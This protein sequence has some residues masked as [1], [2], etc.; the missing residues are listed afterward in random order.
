[1]SEDDRENA[2]AQREYE[3]AIE[4]TKVEQ[5]RYETALEQARS[6][7]KLTSSAQ[8]QSKVRELEEKLARVTQ[9]RERALS[10]A[11]LTRSG[12]VYVISNVGSFGENVFK[13]GMTR[14][15]DPMDR[16]RELGDASVPFAFDVHA[17]I[18]S[19]DAPALERALHLQ[20]DANRVN[21]VNLKKEF[22]VAETEH[23][24]KTLLA[25]IPGAA[26]SVHAEAE[27]YRITQ[28]IRAQ[29]AYQVTTGVKAE[30]SQ[31][32]AA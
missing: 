14:R 7:L 18:W 3:Q 16:V 31:N 17:L 6:E 22:F 24:R 27:Q 5:Q 15:I 10:M 4:R 30:L 19:K 25:F 20:F 32:K 28:N 29:G 9:E 11:Q 1:M 26:F 2:R 21:R 12:Y 23:V 13:I 8:L